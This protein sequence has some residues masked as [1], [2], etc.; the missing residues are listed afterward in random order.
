MHKPARS[1][2]IQQTMKA[3][4]LLFIST[5]TS[6][7]SQELDI[8]VGGDTTTTTTCLTP[9]PFNTLTSSNEEAQPTIHVVMSITTGDY[10]TQLLEGIKLQA[11]QIGSGGVNV[12]VSSADGDQVKQAELITNA[13]SQDPTPIG[14]LTVDGSAD[15]MCT[16]ISNALN[17]TDVQIVSFDFDGEPCTPRHILT[18]QADSDMASFVLTEAITQ[19]GENVNVGY[20]NDL[21]YAPLMNRNEV[22]ESYKEMNNWNQV[23]FVENATEFTDA[24]DLQNAIEDAITSVDGNVDFIYAPWDYL[25]INTVEAI[26]ATRNDSTTGHSIFVYGADINTQDI[27]VMTTEESPWKATAGGDPRAIG[28]SLIRMVAIV[29]ASNEVVNGITQIPPEISDLLPSEILNL[30]NGNVNDEDVVS[31]ID[32]VEGE[33]V[34]LLN[35]IGRY[36]KIPS[37]LV[38]QDFLVENGVHNMDELD[39]ALPELTL[40]DF[41]QVCWIGGIVGVDDN[42]NGEH[43]NNHDAGN[44][45]EDSTANSSQAEDS[46][47]A[48]DVAQPMIV[49]ISSLILVLSS[50]LA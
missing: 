17:N 29:V 34:G 50:T 16:S 19:Q 13:A 7:H 18:S 26:K 45:S 25:S 27:Q 11:T 31:E 40:S 3:P 10:F 2:Y 30:F 5:I 28:A 39:D 49:F 21:N 32:N 36:V 42:D 43:D 38:T 46:S 41:M 12:V 47:S 33:I 15:T 22:W 23:F 9:P 6:G 4:L 20:V 1:P 14:I 24:M 37:I 8:V 35:D 48:K 44:D